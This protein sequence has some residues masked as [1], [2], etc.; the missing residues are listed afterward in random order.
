MPL[1]D[2]FKRHDDGWLTLFFLKLFSST[3]LWQDPEAPTV[4]YPWLQ[5]TILVTRQH[6]LLLRKI[7]NNTRHVSREIETM[8]APQLCKLRV[9]LLYFDRACHLLSG[10]HSAVARHTFRYTKSPVQGNFAALR[11]VLSTLYYSN[12][13]ISTGK[14]RNSRKS[15]P[16]FVIAPIVIWLSIMCPVRHTKN[17]Q[18]RRHMLE[19]T[20]STVDKVRGGVVQWQQ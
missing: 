4:A 17:N 12:V 5:Y 18:E 7:P 9:V 16:A 19:D 10:L 14:P 15:Q 8:V 20:Q 2:S 11:L 1:S 13:S 6:P 3:I